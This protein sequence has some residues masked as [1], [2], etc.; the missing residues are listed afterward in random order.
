MVDSRRIF[1]DA[2]NSANGTIPNYVP[3]Q[4]LLMT[5]SFQTTDTEADK[6]FDI[7][8][9]RAAL[10]DYQLAPRNPKKGAFLE[11][12]PVIQKRLTDGLTVKQLQQILQRNGLS[13]SHA[14]LMR[15]LK[16]AREQSEKLS[17]P[18]SAMQQALLAGQRR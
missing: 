15:Y 6:S 13:I 7:D 9:L 2:R 14:T 4:G 8:K 12:Y 3:A 1:V 5:H 16:E 18:V 11:L 17:G 10:Q